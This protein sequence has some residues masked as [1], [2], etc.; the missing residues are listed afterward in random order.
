MASHITCEAW[1]SAFSAS[2][3]PPVGSATGGGTPE[4][5][6]YSTEEQ[7]F[8]LPGPNP[9]YPWLWAGAGPCCGRSFASLGGV[10]RLW[11]PTVCGAFVFAV[12]RPQYSVCC[13][14]IVVWCRRT[15]HSYRCAINQHRISVVWFVLA[16]VYG[17]STFVKNGRI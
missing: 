10:L 14:P 1:P 4:S 17:R 11:P 8:A 16:S 9:L 13:G 15:S 3:S 2:F 7:L 6:C 5:G 12:W